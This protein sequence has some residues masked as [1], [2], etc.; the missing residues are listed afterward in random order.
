MKKNTL[1]TLILLF[2]FTGC[3]K[4]KHMTS[5]L[6][7]G[8]EKDEKE[9]KKDL[10]NEVRIHK[11]FNST[12]TTHYG[13]DIS[14]FQGDLMQV[15]NPRDSIKFIIC[16]A[17][18][19]TTFLDPKFRSNWREIRDKGFIRGTYHFY[20]CSA[21]PIAQADFFCRQIEDIE[22]T[23]IPPILDIEQGSM[24]KGVSSKQMEQDILN[25]LKRVEQ[26]IKRKPMVYTN[27][28]FAQQNLKNPL[29]A[30]YSLWLAEYNKQPTPL[31]PNLWQ[32]KGFKI[33]QRSASYDAFSRQM[34]LDVMFG[35]IKNIVK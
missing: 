33:W 18:Q 25:F 26:N 12:S 23:D 5:L 32:Q 2:I 17:T 1:Y 24:T 14:H 6:N 15:I 30:D 9:V 35:S 29:L 7:V 22:A 11:L 13:I 4:E 8:F 34:D 16:K 20:D 28:E 3:S 21:D 27:F 10:S 19:G 31:V